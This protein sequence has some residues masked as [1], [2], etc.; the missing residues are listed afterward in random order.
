MTNKPLTKPHPA[1]MEA[2]PTSQSPAYQPRFDIVESDNELTLY[3]DM[4]GVEEKD[5]DVRYEN[6]QLMI[7]AKVPSRKEAETMLCEEYGVGDYQRTFM[8]GESIDPA[9]IN[10][11]IHNGVLVVHL[12]K[13]EAVKPKRIQVKAV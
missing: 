3:G 8:I 10:A 13:T 4:P 6:E 11:E 12:P 1:Q 5:L 2:E 9:K 7:H